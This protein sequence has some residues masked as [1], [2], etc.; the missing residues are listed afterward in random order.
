VKKNNL[1]K[2]DLVK[3][4][5]IKKGFSNNFSAKLINDLLNILINTIKIEDL[6][7]KN[8]GAFKLIKKKKRLGRN[9]K[10]KKEHIIISRNS[11]SFVASKK[12]LEN[13][14]RK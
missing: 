14:N 2:K 9:P 1:T 7:L 12:L 13:L 6:R 10:T 4:L 11:V 8:I 3:N 5:S